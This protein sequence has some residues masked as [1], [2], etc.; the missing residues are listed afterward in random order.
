MRHATR[1]T[2]PSHLKH[3]LRRATKKML[4][5]RRRCL[6]RRVA[7]HVAFLTNQIAVIK[8]DA[9][10]HVVEIPKPVIRTGLR[11]VLI[12]GLGN[13]SHVAS[14]RMSHVALP[15]IRMKNATRC[16]MLPDI[17]RLRGVWIVSSWQRFFPVERKKQMHASLNV[18]A[19]I[20]LTVPRKRLLFSGC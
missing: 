9:T 12:T 20:K 13:L 7:S 4:E 2:S 5:V 6:S 19:V 17:S 16:D 10:R 1:Q 3:L 15:V 11:P 18:N 8:S 14:R